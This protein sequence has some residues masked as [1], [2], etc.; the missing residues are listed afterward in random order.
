MILNL[1]QNWNSGEWDKA[2]IQFYK[3]SNLTTF[4][5]FSQS[6][7]WSSKLFEEILNFCIYK[8]SVTVATYFFTNKML[9]DQYTNKPCDSDNKVLSVKTFYMYVFLSRSTFENTGNF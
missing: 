4:A 5:S 9:F 1:Q 8:T 6:I 2:C 7:S 3:V